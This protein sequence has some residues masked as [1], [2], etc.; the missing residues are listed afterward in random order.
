MVRYVC[1]NDCYDGGIDN[2][3]CS[4]FSR[5]TKGVTIMVES[6]NEISTGS[7]GNLTTTRFGGAP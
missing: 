6:R 7:A 2:D 4:V 1:S 3:K 5:A